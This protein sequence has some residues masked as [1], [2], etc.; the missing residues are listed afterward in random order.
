MDVFCPR[1]GSPM[2]E[3]EGWLT[4]TREGVEVSPHLRGELERFVASHPVK[5]AASSLGRGSEWHCPADGELLALD[6]GFLEC[7]T[8]HRYLPGG[9]LY[10]TVEFNWPPATQA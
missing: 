7:G 5:P 2:S 9:L 4:C 6:D 8:C 1:C 3:V 10:E